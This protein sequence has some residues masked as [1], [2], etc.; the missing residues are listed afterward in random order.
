MKFD[1]EGCMKASN[2]LL[3]SKTTVVNLIDT[4]ESLINAVG[5]NYH[6]EESTELLN[7]LQG[8]R[9]QAPEFS[10]A[11]EKCANYLKDEVAPGYAKVENNLGNALG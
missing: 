10:E 4:L 6:S 5:N 1:Y 2:D 9:K 8:L 11:V 3:T 7:R